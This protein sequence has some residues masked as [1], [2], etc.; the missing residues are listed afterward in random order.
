M[1]DTFIRKLGLRV[2]CGRQAANKDQSRCLII[3]TH[4]D[5]KVRSRDVFSAVAI[6]VG[7]ETDLQYSLCALFVIQLTE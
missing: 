2:P 1:H 6:F 7:S 3:H 5:A 4:R